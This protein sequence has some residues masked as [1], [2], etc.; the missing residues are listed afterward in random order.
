M[1]SSFKKYMI[2][3]ILIINTTFSR[4]GAAKIAWDLHNALNKTPGFSSYFA[5][6]REAKI[7]DDKVFKFGFLPEVYLHAFLTRLTGLQ[8]YG[9]WFSTRRLKKFIL[10]EKF[11]L[12]HLHN[13]HGYYLNLSFIKFLCKLDVPV[14]WT[15]HDAWPI[16]GRCSYFFKCDRWKTGCGNC[17]DLSQYPKTYFDSSAFMW[18]KKKEYFVQGWNPFIVCPSQWLGDKIKESYLNKFRIEVIPNG[19]DTKLFKPKDKIPIRKKL[20]INIH[21]KVILFVANK[22]KEERKGTKYFFEALKYIPEI[23]NYIVLT[24]GEKIKFNLQFKIKQLGY[25][26]NQDLISKI[27]NAADIFC[28]T[29]IDEVFGLTVTESMACGVPVVGFRV[30]GIPEQVTDDCGILVE[31]KNVKGLAKAMDELLNNDEKR[32]AFGLNCRELALKKYS[33]EKFKER[34]INLYKGLLE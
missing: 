7:N 28:I 21:K 15:L 10:K 34:Y 19:I 27:Y 32:K 33:I 20:G 2:K 16:T 13:L 14:V 30:G 17:P 12:V 23:K 22:L 3:K 24:V 5:H 18:K 26:S 31:S 25:V 4:G 9:S 8:G 6:G 11:D 29:S 1:V